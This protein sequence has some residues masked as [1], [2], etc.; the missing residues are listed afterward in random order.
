MQITDDT[1]DIGRRDFLIRSGWVAAGA[2][3]LASCSSVGS[4][5]PVLPSLDD[6]ELEDALAWIQVLPGGRIRFFCPRMEMGQGASLGLSQVVAE[7]LNIGQAEIECVLP[8]TDQT[9]RFKMTVGSESIA[10][11]FEPVSHAAARLREALRMIA[12]K[13]AGVP[14]ENIQ[15]GRGGFVTPDGTVFGY[16]VLVPS[17]PLVLS[18]ANG[19]TTA[20]TPPRYALERKG[21]YQ[22][23]GHGWRHHELE[24]IVTGQTVYSR[25]VTLPGMLYGQVLRPPALGARLESADGRAARS[26][27]GVVAVVIEKE[28]DFIGVVTDDP[29]VL[30]TATRMI[31]ARWRVPEGT[32]QARI[33]ASL[34]VEK[35]RARDDF[36]HTLASSGDIGAGH[37]NASHRTS[38]RYETSFAAHAA[39]EPRAGVGWVK[40]DK[41][42]IWTGSQDPFF[43]QRRVAQAIGRDSDEVVVHSHRMGGGFGG[44]IQCRASEEAAI[45]SAVV[46]R[47]VRVQWSREDE[48]QNNYF[49]PGFSHFVDAGVTAEGKISHWEH[50]FVS[51]P[52]MFGL[53]PGN[54]AWVVDMVAADE[55]TARGG[56]AQYNV[57]NRRVRYSDIRTRVP[58]GTWRGLGAAPNTFAIESMMDELAV[59]ARIDPLE[60]RLGNLPPE[61]KRLADVLRRVAEISKWD[62]PAPR[63]T[64][65]GMACA[66]YKNLTAVAVVVE[67]RVDHGTRELRVTKTWCAQDCGLVVNPSQ[68]ENL[69]MG[70]MVWGCGLALKERVTFEAGVAEQRNFDTYGLLRHHEAPKMTVALIESNAAPVGVGESALAPVAPAIANAVFAA[71]G[72]RIRRL[73]MSYGSVFSD[74]GG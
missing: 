73:P 2:T 60:F 30:P 16:G 41:V 5:L 47:P 1:A 9:P 3:V 37:A 61:S 15:D 66:V 45:L 55:G 59:A 17:E 64:G 39:M 57:A 38:A 44:R 68:V 28:N 7:E 69:V 19:S 71:T 43:V 74:T 4:L 52:I 34:D 21:K 27:P 70:N 36:E 51:S 63:D 14:V 29:F 26:M 20:M 67:V 65:R 24:A 54:I 72:K 32:D 31:D 40:K 23:I 49:Q 18:E 12:A 13:K 35:I 22:A 50:D 8:D 46:G 58:T 6:P 56:L 10:N 48:F 42:E 25:D 33:D 53:V 11:F 62:R